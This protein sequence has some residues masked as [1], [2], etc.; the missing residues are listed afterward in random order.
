M[1]FGKKHIPCRYF[2]S[3]HHSWQYLRGILHYRCRG[4]GFMTHDKP[5][6]FAEFSITP[7]TCGRFIWGTGRRCSLYEGHTDLCA[8]RTEAIRRERPL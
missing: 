7:K 6:D 8:T 1:L 2:K 3:G 4:C 5:S